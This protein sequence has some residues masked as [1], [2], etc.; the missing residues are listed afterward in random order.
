MRLSTLALTS[1]MPCPLCRNT[2]PTP[3]KST[4]LPPSASY[5][6]SERRLTSA[7]GIL[8]SIMA[9]GFRG[10]QMRVTA[11]ILTIENLHRDTPSS[12]TAGLSHGHL[13][14]KPQLQHP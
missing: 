13:N 1:P 4:W 11:R 12:L 8:I 6:I 14:D 9:K 3:P 10:S 7:F 2:S 5:I